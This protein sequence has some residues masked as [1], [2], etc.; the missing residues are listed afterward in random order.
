MAR[1]VL[2][3]LLVLLVHKQL[4][5]LLHKVKLAKLKCNTGYS[6]PTARRSATSTSTAWRVDSC[7]SAIFASCSSPSCTTLQKLVAALVQRKCKLR[8]KPCVSSCWHSNTTMASSYLA[9]ATIL[10]WALLRLVC[11]ADQIC[12]PVE[13][14]VLH[15]HGLHCFWH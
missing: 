15:Q 7:W 13:Q 4:E 6:L 14:F 1:L 3:A 2:L 8:W 10:L 9:L 11:E 12:Q 5:G